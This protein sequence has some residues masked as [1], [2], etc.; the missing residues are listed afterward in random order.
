MFTHGQGVLA[1][2]MVHM[3]R[4]VGNQPHSG[5]SAFFTSENVEL[6]NQS[7]GTNGHCSVGMAPHNF[8]SFGQPTNVMAF[9]SGQAMASGMDNPIILM[10]QNFSA[11]QMEVGPGRTAETNEETTGAFRMLFKCPECGLVKNSN[12]ELEIHIKTEHLGWLP[13]QCPICSALRA[14]DLQMREHIHSHH[15]KSETKYIYVDNLHAQ[16]VLQEMVD[17][18]LVDAFQCIQQKRKGDEPNGGARHQKKAQNNG[19]DFKNG[20]ISA[21]GTAS[22]KSASGCSSDYALAVADEE[23]D[24]DSLLPDDSG[25]QMDRR[26]PQHNMTDSFSASGDGSVHRGW[27]DDDRQRQNQPHEL[28][29]RTVRNRPGPM[30]SKKRVLGL[31]TEC[32]KP[33]T[34]GARQ[35]H[36]FYHLGKKNSYR[37]RCKF[38]GCKVQHY[39][40][41]QMENHQSKVHGK[42]NA[43]M[44]EDRSSELYSLVQEMSMKLLG[45]TGNTPGPTAGEAQRIYERQLREMEANL[46]MRKRRRPDCFGSS[47]SNKSALRSSAGLPIYDSANRRVEELECRRCKKFILNRIKG[48]HILWH[49]NTDLGIVRYG[50]KHCNFKHDR[51]QSVAAHGAREHGD[52]TACVDLL[53]N[54]ESQ[55]L[56]MSKDCFGV[57]RLFEKEIRRRNRLERFARSAANSSSSFGGRIGS[58]ENLQKPN[59]EGQHKLA[60]QQQLNISHPKLLTKNENAEDRE[61]TPREEAKKRRSEGGY[62]FFGVRKPM[63]QKA[64]DEMIKLR[65]VS[66]RLGGA[67]YFRKRGNESTFC[68]KCGK[69]VV[70]RLSDHAYSHLEGCDLFRCQHC[71]LSHYSRDHIARHIKDFHNSQEAPMDN[72]LHFA[73]AIKDAI[74][75]CYP[76][77]FIDAPIPTKEDIDKLRKNLGLS[78]R[79]LVY[80]EE[81]EEEKGEHEVDEGEEEDEEELLKED[82]ND[83][84]EEEE[85]GREEEGEEESVATNEDDD[86]EEEEWLML[87]DEEEEENEDFGEESNGDEMSEGKGEE[88]EQ[89]AEGFDG[90]EQR[91][92]EEEE[93]LYL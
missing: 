91:Q 9:S 19:G 11:D 55:L 82:A 8:G 43:E 24:D 66:K 31:C 34:A 30:T 78:Q 72:R 1:P 59:K 60:Q 65:E 63:A 33:I 54:F 5:G 10:G 39:R 40:K 25:H 3:H 58:D 81:E 15:K 75:Q 49:L 62:R 86:E 26:A 42:I 53:Y 83:D 21:G 22:N 64:R 20:P 84:G 57:E 92:E 88:E 35:M 2:Q 50:C 36:M 38:P 89:M 12:G 46:G 18:A 67:Q 90:E 44:M 29:R 74:R 87:T 28:Y 37:F 27:N 61:W 85:D 4:L 6:V 45:T 16:K 70:N 77:L 7:M 41:D 71:N 47:E 79:V 51:P 52:E 76:Q 32:K 93:V 56:A 14:S 48:F 68:E 80:E 13:F 17:K 73:Q 23:E 69:L